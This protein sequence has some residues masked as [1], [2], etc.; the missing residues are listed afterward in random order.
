MSDKASIL[1]VDDEPINQ[2]TYS[3]IFSNAGYTVKTARSTDEALQILENHPPDIILIDIILGK[4]SGLNLLKKIKEN[5]KYDYIYTVMISGKLISSEDQAS[6]L[7]LGA[8]GYITRPIEKR[9][10]V[11]R[12]DAFMRQK[13]T[14]DSL[15]ISERRLR[16][17]I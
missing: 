3:K 16:K 5:A 7:E 13:K 15:K 17:I 6:G 10:L 4:E 1:L 2:R 8:D 11:A 14:S 12:I 9:E